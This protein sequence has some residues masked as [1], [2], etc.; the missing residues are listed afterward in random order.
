[1][2]DLVEARVAQLKKEHRGSCGRTDKKWD[3]KLS[4]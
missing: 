2:K 1:M 4:S 3:F